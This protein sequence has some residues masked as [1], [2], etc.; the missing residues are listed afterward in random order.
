[1]KRASCSKIRDSPYLQWAVS[2]LEW[3]V[4]MDSRAPTRIMLSDD[5]PFVRRG[6]RNILESAGK[7]DVCGEAGD[8]K[9]TLEL[10]LRLRPDIL[11][12]DISMSPPNGLEVA[13]QL[14]R[15]LPETKILIMTMHDSEEMLRAAAAAGASGYLLKSD[16]EELLGVALQCLAEGQC[17]VSPTFNPEFA[18]LLFK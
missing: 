5:H 12:T 9:V 1:M 3:C 7:Y 14:R 13:A 8:G 17:F 15:D 18:K 11:I 2:A 10:A 16:P 4:L 6:L